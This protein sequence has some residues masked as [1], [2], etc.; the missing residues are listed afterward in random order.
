MSPNRIFR[1]T[2][3]ERMRHTPIATARATTVKVLGVDDFALRRGTRYGTIL[4]DLETH[5]VVDLLQGR[6]RATAG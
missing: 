2:L 4:V 5:R 6:G 3:I 1:P